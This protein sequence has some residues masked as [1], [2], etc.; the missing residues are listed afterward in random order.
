MTAGDKRRAARIPKFTLDMEAPSMTRTSLAVLTLLA[1]CGGDD[2]PTTQPDQLALPGSAY[3]P[4]SLNADA[5]GTLY[6]GGLVAG[7]VVAF[8]DGATDARTVVTNGSGISGVLVHD[9]ELWICSVDTTFASPN[10]IKSF[11]LDGAPHQTFTL[12]ANQFCN[13]L[14]F[15]AAGTL[16]ATDSL[17]GTILRLPA[18]G[19]ALETFLT[20]AQ[21][22]PAAPGA[23]AAD[24]IVVAGDALYVNRFDTGALFRVDIATKALTPITVTPAL[25]APDGMRALDDHTLLVVEGGAGRLSKVTIDG[26]T[27]TATPVA[28]GLDQPT[29]V[30]VARGSAWVSL[31]QLGRLFAMPPQTPNLPFAVVRVDL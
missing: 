25:A 24:G 14:V 10:Q 8:D 28:S 21:L 1:A 13:D 23:F 27:A 16:Y 19:S 15:D 17:T 20:D 4:E 22:A 2:A 31:G 6:V 3:Y 18:G 5:A 11:A 26:T 9:D 29:S 7:T 30:V 12:A